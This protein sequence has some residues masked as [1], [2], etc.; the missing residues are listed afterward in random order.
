MLPEVYVVRVYR[1][2]SG[3]SFRL[4]GRIELPDS[5]RCARF[6]G[7]AELME[8]LRSPRTHLKRQLGTHPAGQTDAR[9]RRRN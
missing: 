6:G 4:I 5:S 2:R 3:R 7:T 8:I 9:V 1:R